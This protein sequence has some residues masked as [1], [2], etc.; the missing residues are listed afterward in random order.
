MILSDFVSDGPI[1]FLSQRNGEKNA[2]FVSIHSSLVLFSWAIESARAILAQLPTLNEKNTR[3]LPKMPAVI[4]I[5][6]LVPET[7]AI[8]NVV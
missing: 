4:P 2:L 5:P 1:S 6:H 8:R 7:F 3:F